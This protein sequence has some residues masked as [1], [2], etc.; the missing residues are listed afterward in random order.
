MKRPFRIKH[1]KI[2]L[3][4]TPVRDIQ[5]KKEKSWG[6]V[7]SNLSKKGKIYFTDPRKH[8][9]GFNDH[10][11]LIWMEDKWLKRERPESICKPFRSEEWKIEYLKIDE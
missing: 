11:D 9:G 7:K 10:T 6:Y 1:K 3:Y 4:Y 8:I 2:G 5:V